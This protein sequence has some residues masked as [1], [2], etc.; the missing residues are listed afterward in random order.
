VTA[1]RTSAALLLLIQSQE[2]RRAT[3][4][5]MRQKDERAFDPNRLRRGLQ[6]GVVR[7]GPNQ[8]R[9][10]GRHETHYDV[11]LDLDVP[12]VCKDA[13]YHGRGCK[14]ELLARLHNGDAALIQSLGDMLL[15][16]EKR[17]AK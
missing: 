9:I 15:S 8:F 2:Q 1:G 6:R 13:E 10:E 11:N 12:C 5:L 7:L 4:G 16:Q 17:K 3:T 14:H